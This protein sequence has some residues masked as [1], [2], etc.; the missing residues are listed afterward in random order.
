MKAICFGGELRQKQT[1]ARRALWT[2]SRNN[3][4]EGVKL[5]RQQPTGSY[6]A[7][8]ASFERKLVIEIDGGQHNEEE[9]RERDFIRY[10]AEDYTL[11]RLRL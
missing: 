3:Q 2:R 10:Y 11:K 9:M 8:S 5:Q 6:V 1:D 4:L 7:D